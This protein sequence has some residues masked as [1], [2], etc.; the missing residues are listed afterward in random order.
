MD[1]RFTKE[2]DDLNSDVY[3]IIYAHDKSDNFPNFIEQ[4]KELNIP[5]YRVKRLFQR[6][7]YI[8]SKY[9]NLFVKFNNNISKNDLYITILENM[10]VMLNNIYDL[11][12]ISDINNV[13]VEYVNQNKKIA[14]RNLIRLIKKNMF[15]F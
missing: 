10:L 2:L 5:L 15:N 4:H 14:Q 13:E 8:R 12:F 1:S 9:S 6:C 11:Y 3:D 7:R